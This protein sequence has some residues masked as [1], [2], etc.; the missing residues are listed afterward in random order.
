VRTGDARGTIYESLR[1]ARESQSSHARS[2]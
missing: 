2:Y 1:V